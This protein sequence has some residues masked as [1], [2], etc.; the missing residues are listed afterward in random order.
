MSARQPWATAET[1][2][3]VR[4]AISAD[5]AALADFLAA[6]DKDGL[7]ER[8]FAHGD[9]PNAALLGR[10][11]NA[12][13]RNRVVLLGVGADATVIGHAEYVAEAGAAE[14][15][16]MVAPAWRDCG[17]GKA[18]LAALLAAATAAGQREMH[19]LIQSTNTRALMVARKHG[20]GIRSG[21]DRRTVIVSRPLA[22]W[23][24]AGSSESE[25]GTT[26]DM[27]DPVHHD[28]DRT[29]LHPC[30]VP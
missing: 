25:P 19:G 12:E 4:R 6:M 21:E 3:C 13:G 1:G 16:L 15:A 28:P 30:P 8:H 10:L 24:A 2:L 9:A 17:L 26:S 7:Y 20:F 23:L 22:P 5:R 14:F 18:L 27:L 29:A 11:A